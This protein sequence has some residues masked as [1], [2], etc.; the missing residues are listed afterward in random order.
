MLD[1]TVERSDKDEE[2]LQIFEE[3]CYSQ[4]FPKKRHEEWWIVVGHPKTGKLLSIKKLAHFKGSK[5][6]TVTV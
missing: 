3:P 2:S 6:S 1:V 4:Y 5:V